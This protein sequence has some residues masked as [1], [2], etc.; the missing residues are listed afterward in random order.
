MSYELFVSLRH[1]RARRR[2]K[3]ISLITW[4][5]VAGVAVG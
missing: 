5:S 3:F 2:R 1:L 4:I